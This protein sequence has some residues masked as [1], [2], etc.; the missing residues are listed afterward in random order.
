M[1]KNNLIAPVNKTTLSLALLPS[2]LLSISCF[3]QAQ[4]NYVER[5]GVTTTQSQQL[6][7][8]LA[9]K[10]RYHLELNQYD[11][12]ISAI[13]Q[14]RQTLETLAA[15]NPDEK[16]KARVFLKH[17]LTA[18]ALNRLLADNPVTVT[19]VEGKV[20]LP[21]SQTTLTV[22]FRNIQSHGANVE[23]ALNH[24][25]TLHQNEAN[26]RQKT[27]HSKATKGELEVAD[28][29][30]KT[31]KKLKYVEA[32][33]VGSNLALVNLLHQTQ[34]IELVVAEDV[35]NQNTLIEELSND[36]APALDQ[37]IE[38]DNFDS[39]VDLPDAQA[40][41]S[42]ICGPL[43]GPPETN[44]PPDKY[45]LP[46]PTLMPGASNSV[47]SYIINYTYNYADDSESISSRS[48]SWSTGSFYSKFK[49]STNPMN[50]AA[51]NNSSLPA[52]DPDIDPLE[53]T[54]TCDGD[55]N[56]VI[57]VPESTYE[58]EGLIPNPACTILRRTG[59]TYDR[60]FGCYVA[61]YAWSN[62][63]SA[64]LDTTFSDGKKFVATIGSFNAAVI[65]PGK[66]YVHYQRFWA[67][68][69][70]NLDL[71]VDRLD[72]GGQIGTRF[73]SFSPAFCAYAVDTSFIHEQLKYVRITW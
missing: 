41:A 71:D 62:L 17:G 73:C 12:V 31:R 64:Y 20:P 48:K 15:N 23:E 13:A 8:Q 50:T 6:S 60:S 1:F 69:S 28:D 39:E 55:Q 40:Q 42:G 3:S 36:V 29:I 26:K 61:D 46:S 38:D 57:Y 45:W 9:D 65:T 56:D 35:V 7:Q 25:E 70:N 44:C 51:Y 14:Q 18:K 67:W 63:P 16:R 33:V 27:N 66:T 5:V 34:D 58:D 19:H 10:V 32:E 21:Q 24:F 47:R 49:W 54:A 68:K 43:T 59:T 72:H 30:F 53:F 22:W 37:S 4:T 11:D 2:A 52:C